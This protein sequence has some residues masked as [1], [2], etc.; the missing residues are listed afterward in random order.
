MSEKQDPKNQ[1]GR[2]S[3]REE[4]DYWVA[5]YAHPNTMELAL[6]LG[7]ICM[8]GIVD[9][10]ERKQAFQEL[11]QEI[12]SDIIEGLTGHRP[13]WGKPQAAPERERGVKP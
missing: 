1:I 10:P 8:A 12:V 5:Y 6:P 9:N 7:Q 4:G 11:M 13:I 2:L 3:L